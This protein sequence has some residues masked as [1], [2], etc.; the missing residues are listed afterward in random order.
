MGLAV[1]YSIGAILALLCITGVAV[2][3]V[4]DEN[5]NQLTE[6]KKESLILFGLLGAVGL[7]IGW[8]IIAVMAVALGIFYGLFL[9][10]LKI[11]RK[12][13]AK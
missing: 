3:W 11:A 12:V 6:D 2:V 8:P 7:F 1:I 13:A 5:A 4:K 10:I 9:L